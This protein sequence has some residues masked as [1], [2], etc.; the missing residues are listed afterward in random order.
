MSIG[1][2]YEPL[3]PIH[4]YHSDVRSNPKWLEG[5]NTYFLTKS[6]SILLTA[7]VAKTNTYLPF[8]LF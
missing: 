1:M 6:I 2:W 7:A 8:Y 4:T 3:Q 5:K